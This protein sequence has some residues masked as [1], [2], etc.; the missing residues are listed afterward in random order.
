MKNLLTL[1]SLIYLVKRQ[2][3]SKSTKK[4]LRESRLKKKS[5]GMQKPMWFKIKG[6]DFEELAR[7]IFN[8]QDNNDFRIIINRRTYGLKNAK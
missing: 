3:K 5:R 8:N 7:D 6:K 4:I 2:Q 1:T